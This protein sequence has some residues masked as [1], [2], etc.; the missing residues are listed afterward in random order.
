MKRIKKFDGSKGLEGLDEF[1]CSVWGTTAD[2]KRFEKLERALGKSAE[3]D[4]DFKRLIAKGKDLPPSS[5][6]IFKDY[7]KPKERPPIPASLI[8]GWT[9]DAAKC[10]AVESNCA[11]CHLTKFFPAHWLRDNCRVVDCVDILIKQNFRLIS[12]GDLAEVEVG[13]TP[14]QVQRV[15]EKFY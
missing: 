6:N 12:K 15:R 2:F 14:E 13:L 5:P 11:E 1:F 7:G 9:V 8:T 4:N 10:Y 3:F